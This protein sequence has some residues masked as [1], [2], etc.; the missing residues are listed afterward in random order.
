MK[1]FKFI[2]QNPKSKILFLT[3]S[4][5]WAWVCVMLAERF[6]IPSA[7]GI[8]YS[9]PFAQARHALDL[10]VPFLQDF[11]GYG[12]HWGHHW[13][14]AM[15]L[16]GVAFQIL[17]YSRGADL[18]ILYGFQWLVAT[19]TAA[20]VWKRTGSSW[21]SVAVWVVLLSDRLMLQAC[22]GNRFES[23]AIS[24]V[25]LMLFDHMTIHRL[26]DKLTWRVLMCISAA[27][28][29]S[30]HP[31]SLILGGAILGIE[32]WEARKKPR[33]S[34]DLPWKVSGYLV[35]IA[36]CVIWFLW[37]PVAYQH[38]LENLALQKSFYRNP[39]A[40]WSSLQ[41]YRLF[42]GLVLWFSGFL[43]AVGLLM[44]Y[45]R[46]GSLD[47]QA[48]H[49]RRL[50]VPVAMLA[51]IA[52]IHVVSQCENF[53]YLAFGAPLALI[54]IASVGGVPQRRRAVQQAN[55]TPFSSWARWVSASVL[56]LLVLLHGTIV[57]FRLFQFAKAGFPNFA[58]DYRN[59]LAQLA[60]DRTILIPHDFWAAAIQ[61]PRRDVRWFTFPIASKKETRKA[62]EDLIYPHLKPGDLL[63]LPSANVVIED[64]FGVYPT[65]PIAPPDPQQWKL[66][67]ETNRT[68][69]GSM[70][71]SMGHRVYEK[72]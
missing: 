22:A 71:W 25:M 70:D 31:Y 10:G 11:R 2:V 37:H 4:F 45:K 28:A 14:G 43:V 29:A 52:V 60:E 17:P 26:S 55:S 54:L 47:Q 50:L 3:I 63:I 12:N 65:F 40:F 49:D 27:I 42:G 35:G 15:W 66:L 24:A 13:P 64:R 16:R 61:F 51:L 53:H 1:R 41:N 20:L 67:S 69:S 72:L 56:A 6:S 46:D 5:I 62:Y 23:V 36:A 21:R 30:A 7:D 32:L 68:F 57:P 59:A 33:R 58:D 9:L 18:W 39:F 19:C 48:S 8:M 44:R 34:T 38:L